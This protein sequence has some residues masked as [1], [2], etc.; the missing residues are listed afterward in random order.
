MN[1]LDRDSFSNRAD[2]LDESERGLTERSPRRP[3]PIDTR[4]I[5]IRFEVDLVVTRFYV[6]LMV[7][8]DR[9]DRQRDRQ[10]RGLTKVGNT[11]AAVLLLLSTNLAI[12]GFIVLSLYLLK[13]M[14]GINLMPEHI[15]VYL[16]QLVQ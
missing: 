11:I 13:S 4:F 6:V 16:K 14:L 12:S 8:K 7:G 5:D 15:T 10:V 2:T 3:K 9:R 1:E